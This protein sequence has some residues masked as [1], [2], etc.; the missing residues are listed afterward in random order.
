MSAQ[1]ETV[2]TG[3]VEAERRIRAWVHFLAVRSSLTLL[4]IKVLSATWEAGAQWGLDRYI[5]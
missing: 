3:P 5:V 4:R 1:A 2:R